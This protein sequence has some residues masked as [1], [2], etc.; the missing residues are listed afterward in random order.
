MA[1]ASAPGGSWSV[2]A[3][4]MSGGTRLT[5]RPYH[6]RGAREYRRTHGRE[7]HDG[8]PARR[9]P[10][11]GGRATGVLRRAGGRAGA[12]REDEAA[13]L[14]RRGRGGGPR[15]RCAGARGAPAS[16]R[17]D[18]SGGA[19]GALDDAARGRLRAAL[20]VPAGGDGGVRRLAKLGGPAD[21]ACVDQ[22][23]DA[24][25]GIAELAEHRGAIGAEQRRRAAEDRRRRLEVDEGA[26]HAERAERRV[27]R[28][29]DAA[30]GA[31]QRVGEQLLEVEARRR[32]HPRAGEA[33]E[34]LRARE[35]A[36][37]ARHRGGRGALGGVVERERHAGQAAERRGMGLRAGRDAHP[38]VGAGV[39]PPAREGS[40]EVTPAGGRRRA[41]GGEDH[42]RR[43]HD[44]AGA[45]EAHVDAL[46]TPGALAR[47]ERR[48]GRERAE[49]GRVASGPDEPQPVIEVWTRSGFTS[50][51][52]SQP[53]PSRS[54]TPARKL[55]TSTS[56]RRARSRNTSRPSA[57][58]RSST[59]ERL[60]RFQPTKPKAAKRNGS[61]SADSIFSTSAPRS[62]SSMGQNGPA[63]KLARSRTRMPSRHSRGGGPL[64]ANDGRR[65]AGAAARTAAVSAPGSRAG[66]G[67]GAGVSEKRAG[68]PG[69][70]VAPS[71][72][73]SSGTTRPSPRASGSRSACS[74]V[75]TGPHGMSAAPSTPSHSAVVR[76]A[77][78][79]SSSRRTKSL[80]SGMPKAS[81]LPCRR[82][83]ASRSARSSTVISFTRKAG[84]RAPMKSQPSAVRKSE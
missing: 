30:G 42:L 55:S 67:R 52:V 46:P 82:G 18:P 51:S 57:R 63:M 53:R 48:H 61:P 66:R 5:G 54:I 29:G 2:A 15:A 77:R 65:Q 44:V 7:D 6:G 4:A 31:E 40:E 69:C 58:F 41:S 64:G 49:R 17:G 56:A 25:R 38:P 70:Q 34:C 60:P 68:S 19:R 16:A 84:V 23:G 14:R 27:A 35:R 9:V 72:G 79:G 50:W 1:P 20:A 76:L 10:G 36:E 33:G 73:S 80:I 32:R 83:S 59:S 62:A 43:L 26:A 8:G 47:N 24:L 21:D 71:R 81:G 78:I 22:R 28:L 12:R 11:R 37:R 45:E 39:E 74:R 3:S 13:R 75:R